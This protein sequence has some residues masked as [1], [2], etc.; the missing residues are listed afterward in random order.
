MRVEFVHPLVCLLFVLVLLGI[1]FISNL[2]PVHTIV[3][4][5]VG[6]VR[7]TLLIF[8]VEEVLVHLCIANQS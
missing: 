4:M 2:L 1:D 3:H 5:R 7:D 6:T 8:Q